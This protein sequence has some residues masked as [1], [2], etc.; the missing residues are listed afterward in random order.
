MYGIETNQI[1]KGKVTEISN[2]LNIQC[3][4]KDKTKS[5]E[6]YSNPRMAGFPSAALDKFINIILDNNYTVVVV[7]QVTPPPK[8]ERKVTKILS[9]GT[10]YNNS[11]TST[12]NVMSIYIEKTGKNE[13]CIGVSIIDVITGK[14]LVFETQSRKDDK[15]YGY[16]EI[17]R[18]IQVHNPTELLIN[19]KNTGM[20]REEIISYFE[21]DNISCHINIENSHIKK[22]DNIEM[23]NSQMEN[24]EIENS[25][26][27]NSEIENSNT[28]IE[29]YYKIDKNCFNLSYQKKFLEKIFKPD[30]MLSV[31]EYLDLERKIWGLVSYILLLQFKYSK[32]YINTN[33]KIKTFSAKTQ[34]QNFK[35]KFNYK[36]DINILNNYNYNINTQI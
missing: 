34:L 35:S 31:I 24:L 18:M 32:N 22:K 9:P 16:E 7:E 25:E 1:N 33:K 19:V 30:S 23:K 28:D 27:Q 29:N 20:T 10:N 13:I 11:K 4:K 21:I 14:N 2:L 3:T 12:A 17:F 6:N 8:P 26:K 5:E 36:F 15:D